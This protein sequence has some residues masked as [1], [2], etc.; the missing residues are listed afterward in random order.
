MND[1]AACIDQTHARIEAIERV[2]ERSSLGG[3]QV[4]HSPDQNGAANM[5]DDQAHPAPCFVINEAVP[6]MA[7][8][9][10]HGDACRRFVENGTD[11]IDETLRLH[12]FS[13]K[14]CFHELIIRHE[15]RNRDGEI[16]LRE[17]M[18]RR[19]RIQPDIF[20]EIELLVVWIYS[21]VVLN[22]ALLSGRVL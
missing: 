1:A 22:A 8:H 20:V 3:L 18:S 12:P 6:C 11:E 5:G 9:T 14:S 10:E 2:G 7:K 17:K 16:D 21:K 15:V 13:I 19:G 4:E